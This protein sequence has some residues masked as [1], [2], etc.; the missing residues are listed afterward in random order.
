MNLI[1]HIIK[2][3]LRH[4]RWSLVL[5]LAC[6]SYV[7]FV[8][9]RLNFHSRTDLQDYFRL[10]SL[11]TITVLSIAM[12][13][14]IVQQDHP[15]G[16]TAFW[17]TRP[18]SAGRLLAAKL[19]LLG[20]VFIGIPLLLV[21]LG[22]WLHRLVLLSSFREFGLMVLVLG[23]ITLSLAA[24]SA[25]TRTILYALF[26]A[27]GLMFGTGALSESLSQ[28]VPKFSAKVS[29]QMNNSRALALLGFSVV[30]ALMILG[31]QYF[32]RRLG[33][34]ILLL[35]FASVGSALIGSMWGYFYFYT[36]Q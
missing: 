12:L 34:S 23:A 21:L 36:S 28:M 9:E 24:V 11:V 2:K 20:A 4:F 3:D 35:V 31:N 22:G 6:L 26:L 29:M 30:T 8:Q 19:T 25:C 17:R 18:I 16:S 14:S 7:F 1:W 13:I 33:Y 27:L 5:W 10:M 32:K 15:T